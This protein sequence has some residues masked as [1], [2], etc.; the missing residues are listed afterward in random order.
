LPLFTYP[1]NEK[2]KG[3]FLQNKLHNNQNLKEKYKYQIL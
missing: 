3:G 2:C 1:K